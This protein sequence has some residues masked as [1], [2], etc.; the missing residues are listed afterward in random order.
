MARLKRVEST[1]CSLCFRGKWEHNSRQIGKK[2]R[3]SYG[4]IFSV[5]FNTL[6]QWK[7]A[8]DD[9]VAIPEYKPV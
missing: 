2:M 4:R 3:L 7:S 9:P 1:S 6:V 5:T 8:E